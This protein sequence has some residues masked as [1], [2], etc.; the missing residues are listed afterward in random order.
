MRLCVY[1]K[2]IHGMKVADIKIDLGNAKLGV[3]FLYLK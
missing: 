1:V 3:W 2:V